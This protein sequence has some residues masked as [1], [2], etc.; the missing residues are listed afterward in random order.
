MTQIKRQLFSDIVCFNG[1]ENVCRLRIVW[2]CSHTAPFP[3]Y[4]FLFSTL[5]L[6]TRRM[7]L[8]NRTYW[9]CPL[10]DFF[11]A[12]LCQFYYSI[13]GYVYISPP[14]RFDRC[15]E[16]ARRCCFFLSIN[17]QKWFSTI[18]KRRMEKRISFRIDRQREKVSENIHTIAKLWW[19]LFCWL[20]CAFPPAAFDVIY[21]MFVCRIRHVIL[22]FSLSLFARSI[23][24]NHCHLSFSQMALH[25]IV[26]VQPF[27]FLFVAR[28]LFFFSLYLFLCPL[29]LHFIISNIY[30]IGT[31]IS[32]AIIRY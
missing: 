17:Q 3:F 6:G 1:Y 11:F 22:F 29:A 10:F 8:N 27:A 26:I 28:K 9:I 7:C 23:A 19:K 12:S 16:G 20:N 5:D 14:I 4:A 31:I 15:N 13:C 25:T 2:L 21:T 18:T 24:F 32:A 30:C